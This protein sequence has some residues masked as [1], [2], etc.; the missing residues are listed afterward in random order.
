MIGFA[1]DLCVTKAERGALQRLAGKALA[2]HIAPRNLEPD[3]R[4]LQRRDLYAARRKRFAPAAI[5]SKLWPTR[6]A[7]RKQRCTGRDGFLDAVVARKSQRAVFASIP[8]T[9]FAC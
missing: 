7:E 2:K 9:A 5:R 6:A 1:V 4:R 3:I 8:A